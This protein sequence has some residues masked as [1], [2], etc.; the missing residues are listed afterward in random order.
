MK[1]KYK[2]IVSELIRENLRIVFIEKNNN[3]FLRKK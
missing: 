1:N 2:K 3:A